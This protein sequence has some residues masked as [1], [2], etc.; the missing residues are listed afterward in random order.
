MDIKD[1]KAIYK[2]LRN[3]D[4]EEIE[5]EDTRGKLRVKR[6]SA[7]PLPKK[8]S[9]RAS[10]GSEAIQAPETEKKQTEKENIKTITSPMVGT[11]Y[12]AP[13]PEA[14]AFVENGSPI[15]AGQVVCIIEAMKLMNEIESDFSGKIL[16]ILVENGQPVEYGE[17]L[18]QVE[19]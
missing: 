1:I 12:R 9:A 14:P 18:F 13:S 19:V 3:T 8:T 2:F 4:I 15:K 11:F 17:P 16:S 7:E 6:G 10:A 5:V